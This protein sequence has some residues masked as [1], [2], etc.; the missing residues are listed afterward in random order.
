MQAALRTFLSFC[1]YQGYIEHP[2]DRA[3]P[4]LRTYKLSTVPRALSQQQAR[5]IID[6][7]DCSTNTG[8]RDYAILQLLNTYGSARLPGAWPATGRYPLG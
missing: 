2:L 5:K 3:V 1:L 8:R 7:V 6:A 4:K